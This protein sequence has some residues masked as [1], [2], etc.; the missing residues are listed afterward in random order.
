LP[1]ETFAR[2]VVCDRPW[3]APQDEG[4]CAPKALPAGFEEAKVQ[5]IKD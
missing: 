1:F 5:R 4:S 2:P 3:Q